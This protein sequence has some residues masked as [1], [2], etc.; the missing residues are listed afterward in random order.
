LT[1]GFK[2]DLIIVE[3]YEKDDEINESNIPYKYD[4]CRPESPIRKE[5]DEYIKDILFELKEDK[6]F[7]YSSHTTWATT[8]QDPYVWIAGSLTDGLHRY[9]P[10]LSEVE[11]YIQQIN[12]YLNSEGFS[13]EINYFPNKENCREFYIYFKEKSSS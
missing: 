8:T 10:V 7:T 12:S 3:F 11:P 6:P 2:G 4:W 5:I 13:T 9:K 1:Y